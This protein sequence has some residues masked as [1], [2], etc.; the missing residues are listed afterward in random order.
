MKGVCSM[1]TRRE[2]TS[3]GCLFNEY[4]TGAHYR[5]VFVQ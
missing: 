1:S 3:E 4:Q 5:R 2:V